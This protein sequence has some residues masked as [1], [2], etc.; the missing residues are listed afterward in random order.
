MQGSAFDDLASRVPIRFWIAIAVLF[1]GLVVGLLVRWATRKLLHAMGVPGAIEGTTFD[2]TARSFGTSTVGILANL[3][4]YFV[5]GVALSVAF[6]VTDIAYVQRLLDALASFI[7]QLFLAVLVLIIGVVL[8]DKVELFVAERFRGVKLPQ[9]SVVPTLAKYSVFYLTALIAL[10]QVDVATGALLILLAAYVFALVFL[11]GIAFHQLLASG[12][13]GTYL[14]LRQPYTIGDEIRVGE[15][16]GIV[17][18]MD[19]FVTH[20]ESD[21]EEFVLPNSKVF[22]DGFV[23][24]R[25]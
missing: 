14:L 18:E 19:L 22:S 21:D 17:Q 8:G 11:G 25:S 12:A 15:T 23:R 2:R 5:L 9:I 13:A 20:V 10:G 6:A 1:V 3:A 16:R 4:G 7:P 24:I